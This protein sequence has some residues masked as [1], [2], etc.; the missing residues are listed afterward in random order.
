MSPPSCLSFRAHGQ[1]MHSWNSCKFGLLLLSLVGGCTV[2]PNYHTPRTPLPAEFS[3]TTQP[4]TTQAASRPAPTEVD[5]TRWWQTFNDPALNR[6]ID[7]AVARNLDVRLANAR[8]REARA[9]LEFNRAALFPTLDSSAS[10]SRS[11]I[12]KNAFAPQTTGGTNGTGTGT[13][14][15]TG[16]GTGGTTGTGTTT[17]TT[18]SSG[19]TVTPFSLGRTN[20]YRA[21]FDAGWEIDVFGG[22]RRAIEAAQ[23]SLEAQVEARRNT[24]VTLLS[25]VAQNYIILRGL[26]HEEQVVRNNLEAQRSTLNL[27]QVKLQAGLTNNLTI[28]QAQALAASTESELPTLDTEIQQTIQRLAV[29]LDRDPTSIENELN[30]PANIPAGPP[31]IPPGLP[32]DLVRRR[33]DVRQ[34]ERQLAAATANIGVAKADLFPKFSL[35]GSLGLESLQL[36]TLANSASAFWSFGPTVSWRI[37]DSGQI[38]ANVHVQNARQEEAL[39][40]YRQAIIQSLADVENALTAYNR[41]QARNSSLRGAVE[42]NRQAVAL[43]KQLNEAGVVDFLNVLTAQQ[44][45]YQS[46]DQLAQSDQTVS[47]DLIALYKALGGGWETTEQAV[48]AR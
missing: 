47:T 14:G 44:S 28:A 30:G 3:A 41:E 23:Y 40:Q 9:Q 27:Q 36:K 45:L 39:I 16:T 8:I 32:S 7:E 35:T 18:G 38:W 21:G 13:G 33:P 37:F 25:E 22:T 1:R 48:S 4:A 17:G 42:A 34:A 20:L 2:G 43:S 5:L 15:T 46:E 26:Q 29:L 10:Y 24:L 19:S 12:S 11:Q 31:S 6:L